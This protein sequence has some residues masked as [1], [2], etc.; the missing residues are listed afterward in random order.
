MPY[1]FF[2]QSKV[3]FF[4]FLPFVT[5]INNCLVIKHKLAAISTIMSLPEFFHFAEIFVKAVLLI[6]Q[7][8]ASPKAAQ[9][10]RTSNNGHSAS[11]SRKRKS[12]EEEVKEQVE[13]AKEQVEEERPTRAKRVKTMF[14]RRNN[15]CPSPLRQAHRPRRVQVK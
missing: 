6:D 14:E 3:Y 5:I 15:R 1:L 2:C 7:E 13:E 9:N 8:P 4:V 11:T 10:Q 12:R